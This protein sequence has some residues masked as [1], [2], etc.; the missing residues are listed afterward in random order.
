MKAR[1]YVTLNAFVPSVLGAAELFGV[2]EQLGVPS[3]RIRVVLNH[4]HP[5]FRGCLRG[6]DVADRLGRDIDFVVPYSRKV[7]TATNAGGEIRWQL[8]EPWAG[9]RPFITHCAERA[10]DRSIGGFHGAGG[11]SSSVSTAGQIS[12]RPA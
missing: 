1:V 4:S 6:V 11:S 8:G 2:L 12:T 5:R 9:E 10:V 3:E 7:L